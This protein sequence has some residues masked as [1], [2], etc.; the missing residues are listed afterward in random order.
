[1]EVFIYDTIKPRPFSA[2]TVD[3]QNFEDGTLETIYLFLSLFVA[4]LLPALISDGVVIREYVRHRLLKMLEWNKPKHTS[5]I[6]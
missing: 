2:R 4:S 3:I 5:F 1:M 6:L